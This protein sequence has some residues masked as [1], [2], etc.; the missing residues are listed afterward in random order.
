[1]QGHGLVCL[2]GALTQAVALAEELEHLAAVQLH[3]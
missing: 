2:G 1:M 3:L